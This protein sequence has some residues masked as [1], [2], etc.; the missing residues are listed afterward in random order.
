MHTYN[1]YGHKTGGYNDPVTVAVMSCLTNQYT[2][3]YEVS[4]T[5]LKTTGCRR[6]IS[7]PSHNTHSHTP[8]H[9]HAHH[10]DYSH[11]FARYY[12]DCQGFLVILQVL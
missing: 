11:L 2:V 7:P 4:E 1:K 12:Y 6:T 8:S 9:T 5:Q 10:P 3:E